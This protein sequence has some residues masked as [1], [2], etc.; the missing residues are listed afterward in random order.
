VDECKP[1]PRGDDK[2]PARKARR[3]RDC[4]P[5]GG[6]GRGGVHGDRR[7]GLNRVGGGGGGSHAPR[8]QG[9]TSVD[10]LFLLLKAM[11]VNANTFT[12]PHDDVV[13]NGNPSS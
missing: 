10:V 4:G 1:L 11:E 13:T 7:A 9:L 5:A 2:Q 3:S 12:G 6:G 8:W